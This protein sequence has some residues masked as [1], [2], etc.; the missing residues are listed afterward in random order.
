MPGDKDNAGFWL[1]DYEPQRSFLLGAIRG[2]IRFLREKDIQKFRQ[3]GGIVK[4]RAFD[5]FHRFTPRPA[6][7]PVQ[8]AMQKWLG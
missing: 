2:E 3:R 5:A 7:L 4:F 6:R 1:F 8:P